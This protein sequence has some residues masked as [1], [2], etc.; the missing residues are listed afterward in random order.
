MAEALANTFTIPVIVFNKCLACFNDH[1]LEMMS[2]G[3][4]KGT[5]SKYTPKNTILSYFQLQNTTSEV[6]EIARSILNV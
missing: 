3:R 4:W 2:C 1:C 6:K 5:L